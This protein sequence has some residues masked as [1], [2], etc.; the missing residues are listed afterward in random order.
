MSLHDL[1]GCFVSLPIRRMGAAGAFLGAD[2][3]D[4]GPTVLLLGPEMLDAEKP[5]F[6]LDAWVE[7][8]AWRN[9]PAIGLFVIV[10]R[11]FVGLV[12][13]TEPHGLARGE[14]ARFRVSHIF[15]D[16]KIELSLRGHAHEEIETD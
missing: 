2:E 15:P 13:L 4:D 12:P 1:L 14:A 16:K 9:D 11:A 10:E 5:D 7:G 3:R 6:P 8:E